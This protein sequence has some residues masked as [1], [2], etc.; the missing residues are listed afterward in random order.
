MELLSRGKTTGKNYPWAGMSYMKGTVGV[1]YKWVG[2]GAAI[3]LLASLG[4]DMRSLSLLMLTWTRRVSVASSA[5]LVVSSNPSRWLKMDW[6]EAFKLCGWLC[7]PI[8][9]FAGIKVF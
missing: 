3:T 5:S 8:W 9:T 2:T 7:G 4:F 1:V 6:V